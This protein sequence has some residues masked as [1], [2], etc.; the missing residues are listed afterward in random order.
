MLSNKNL[1]INCFCDIDRMQFLAAIIPERPVV[2][3]VNKSY[4]MKLKVVIN[5]NLCCV[6]AVLQNNKASWFSSRPKSASLSTW[7]W[8]TSESPP[9][10]ISVRMDINKM[11]LMGVR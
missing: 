6:S 5:I 3:R 1:T 4:I 2:T 11:Y 8:E 9:Y 7:E 10:G